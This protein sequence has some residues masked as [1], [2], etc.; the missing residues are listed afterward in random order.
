[1][2]T[3]RVTV[4]TLKGG[5]VGQSLLM[6]ADR[7][8]VACLKQMIASKLNGSSSDMKLVFK[9]KPLFDERVLLKNA[10]IQGECTVHVVHRVHGGGPAGIMVS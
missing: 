8:T 9:A 3:A 7:N 2:T 5:V 4:V 10:G 1:M 6:D